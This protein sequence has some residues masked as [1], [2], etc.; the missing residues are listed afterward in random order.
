MESFTTIANC[1]KL[2]TIVAK[3]STLGVFAMVLPIFGFLVALFGNQISFCYYRTTQN[4]MI[5]E[6]KNSLKEKLN[7][8]SQEKDVNLSLFLSSEH[9][10]ILCLFHRKNIFFL[11]QNTV[12][13][14]MNSVASNKVIHKLIRTKF[15]CFEFFGERII[16]P[17][18]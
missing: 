4:F 11:Y 1:S 6:K 14:H 7:C 16:L 3:P 2:L 8:I 17:S 10:D 13:V 9:C 15:F 5:S 12:Q 18:L